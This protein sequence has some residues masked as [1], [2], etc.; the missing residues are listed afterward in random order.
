MLE[1][2]KTILFFDIVDSSKLW[3]KY[4]TK[5]LKI[6]KYIQSIILKELKIYK[7]SLLVKC[8]G[9]GFMIT[10]KNILDA[11][12]FSI[13]ICNY[14][15]KPNKKLL[16]KNERIL[17]KIGICHGKMYEHKINLQSSNLLDY[18]GNTVNIAARVQSKV[19][20]VNGFGIAF[21]KK[22]DPNI[23]KVKKIIDKYSNLSIQGLIFK[24]INTKKKNINEHHLNTHLKLY[25][26]DY[27]IQKLK[28]IRTNLKIF[29]VSNNDA[30]IPSTY[31][32]PLSMIYNTN[33]TKNTKNKSTKKKSN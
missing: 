8:L 4:N 17:F 26:T 27:N 19:A 25:F 5:I 33:N 14:F 29:I 6:L 12:N 21:I 20:P 2:S 9:D 31:Y 7:K 23:I 22:N 11:V 1:V 13:S 24:K 10:F 28:G 18:F 3:H 32:S 16:I 15:I 30:N